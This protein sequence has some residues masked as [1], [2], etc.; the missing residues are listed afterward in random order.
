[1]KPATGQKLKDKEEKSWEAA[2]YQEVLL[3]P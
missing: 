3:L 2:L 1:M